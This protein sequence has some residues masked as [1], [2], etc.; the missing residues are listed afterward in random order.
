[1][2]LLALPLLFIFALSID[3]AFS[4]QT[5]KPLTNQ[6]IVDMTKA[7]LG[8]A[9]IAKAIETNETD[10]DTDPQTLI[11]LKNSGVSDGVLTSML[12]RKKPKSQSADS[13][14]FPAEL[15]LYLW[16]DG[17]PVQVGAEIVNYRT[18]G[19]AE[20]F[21]TGVDKGHT[22]G[23]VNGP[24]SAT[25]TNPPLEFILVTPDGITPSEYLLVKLDE[26]SDRR[27][28]REETS[29][30]F[31]KSSGPGRNAVP[32]EFHPLAPR[33]YRVSIGNLAQGEYGFLPPNGLDNKNAQ[34]S[35]RIFAFSVK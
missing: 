23:V 5:K 3:A 13:G 9:T 15:G 14:I 25:P 26:K 11:A 33:T 24:H 16:K 1:M 10:F 19:A 28:F 34:A 8:E 12:S 32:F 6:D 35:R 18:G 30:M 2:K 20:K 21:L 31:S 7:G 27:E 4:A 17:I 29:H 22:N